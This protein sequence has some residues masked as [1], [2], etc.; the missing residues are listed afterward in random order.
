MQHDDLPPPPHPSLPHPPLQRSVRVVLSLVMLKAASYTIA[1]TIFP[2]DTI[3]FSR[4]VGI[5]LTLA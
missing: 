3:G 1:A 2:P 5:S 4:F